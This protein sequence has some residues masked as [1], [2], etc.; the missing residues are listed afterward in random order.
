MV[1]GEDSKVRMPRSQIRSSLYR[2]AIIQINPSEFQLHHALNGKN[3]AGHKLKP[4]KESIHVRSSS[5]P[6]PPTPL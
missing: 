3:I 6:S 4:R 2:L 1:Y 5:S